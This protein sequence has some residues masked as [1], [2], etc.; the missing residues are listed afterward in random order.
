MSDNLQFLNAVAHNGG[1]ITDELR[2]RYG[3]PRPD[4]QPS[5]KAKAP[6]DPATPGA[7]TPPAGADA[8]EI[9]ADWQ[10][11]KWM[12]KQKLAKDI[13]PDFEPDPD[14]RVPSIDAVIEAELTRRAGD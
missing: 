2:E 12:V 8:D 10:S 7:D 9:P 3:V 4:A 13:D 1:V 6:V 5:R 11:L 14:N